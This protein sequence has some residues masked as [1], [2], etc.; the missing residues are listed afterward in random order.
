MLD[1][2][3]D[4]F[5]LLLLSLLQTILIIFRIDSLSFIHKDYD[6]HVRIN[7]ILTIIIK[8][9]W[10]EAPGMF[11]GLS[12]LTWLSLVNLGSVFF[13]EY[14]LHLTVFFYLCCFVSSLISLLNWCE[15]KTCFDLPLVN[16][17]NTV[18]QKQLSLLL[19]LLLLLLFCFHFTL[20]ITVKHGRQIR[21]LQ[22]KSAARKP[23][24]L[25]W[26]V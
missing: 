12:I 17:L 15:R 13:C 22:L 6:C 19:L 8:P 10:C 2:D 11:H 5:S 3:M 18:E 26:W 1:S 9:H 20:S 25:H 16:A 24:G 23:R 4:V 14:M 21:E 7:Q